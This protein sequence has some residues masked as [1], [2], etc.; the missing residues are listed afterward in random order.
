MVQLA[1][2]VARARRA[3]ERASGEAA[4]PGGAP[5]KARLTGQFMRNSR[6][7]S[8]LLL[9]AHPLTSVDVGRVKRKYH[10]L[11]QCEYYIGW[12]SRHFYG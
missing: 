9:T 7:V 8:D 5:G 4:G 3:S 2:E 11:V 12:N 1:A 10:S 6:N